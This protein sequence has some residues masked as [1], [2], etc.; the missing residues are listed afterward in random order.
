MLILY[1]YIQIQAVEHV[2]KAV[3]A[4]DAVEQINM[5]LTIHICRLLVLKRLPAV[6]NIKHKAQLQVYCLQVCNRKAGG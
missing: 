4:A 6:V 3:L 5:L 1:I 2:H